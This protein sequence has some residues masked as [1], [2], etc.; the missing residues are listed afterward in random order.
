MA[1]KDIDVIRAISERIRSRAVNAG[2]ENTER[3]LQSVRNEKHAM[4]ADSLTFKY[5]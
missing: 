4:Q 5:W 2:V 3:D 1:R